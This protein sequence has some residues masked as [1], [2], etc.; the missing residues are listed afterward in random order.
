MVPYGNSSGGPLP[1]S[2]QRPTGSE[3]SYSDPA[4]NTTISESNTRQAMAHHRQ[5]MGAPNN[6]EYMRASYG[7]AFLNEY[8][9]GW[10]EPLEAVPGGITAGLTGV[11]DTSAKG[12]EHGNGAIQ[13]EG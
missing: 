7:E 4:S 11:I 1:A 13:D 3:E 12:A 5:A 6:S 8:V 9:A 10:D 2:I